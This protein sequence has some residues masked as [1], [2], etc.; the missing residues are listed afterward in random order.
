MPSEMREEMMRG[1]RGWV[2]AD[3]AIDAE[4]SMNENLDESSGW[5]R[6][7]QV[8][9]SFQAVHGVWVFKCLWVQ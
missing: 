8:I 3:N 9:E 2:T 4:G 6:A 1:V 5:E 7:T